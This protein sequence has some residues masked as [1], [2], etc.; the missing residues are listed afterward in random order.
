M[1]WKLKFYTILEH[2]YFIL[3]FYIFVQTVLFYLES[4]LIKKM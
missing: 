4:K 1:K 3:F 2:F